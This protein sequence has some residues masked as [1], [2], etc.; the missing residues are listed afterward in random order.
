MNYA[1]KATT[2]F[3]GIRK[4]SMPQFLSE[5]PRFRIFQITHVDIRQVFAIFEICFTDPGPANKSQWTKGVD[6]KDV[7]G[8]IF[9]GK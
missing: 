4:I 6:S 5:I 2:T 1:T 9:S 8:Y 3:A 7:A